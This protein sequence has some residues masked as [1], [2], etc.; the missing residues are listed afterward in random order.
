MSSP[1]AVLDRAVTVARTLAPG[2]LLRT[3]AAG[4]LVALPIV[5]LGYLSGVEGVSGVTPLAALAL[6]AGWLARG[7]I[8]A[9]VLRG[10]IARWEP[11]SLPTPRDGVG[12]EPRFAFPSAATHALGAALVAGILP[13]FAWGRLGWGALLPTL[14]LLALRVVPCP[15][16]LGRA[17]ESS[18]R[19]GGSGRPADP[20]R[21][22][23]AAELVGPGDRARAY[24]VEL[25]VLAATVLLAANLLAALGILSLLGRGVLGLDPATAEAF[26]SPRHGWAIA[27]VVLLAAG[28]LEPVRLGVAVVDAVDDVSRRLGLDIHRLIDEAQAA[29]RGGPPT[30]E[31]EAPAALVDRSSRKSV[32]RAAVLGGAGLLFPSGPPGARAQA[33]SGGDPPADGDRRDQE[34]EALAREILD[35]AAFREARPGGEESGLLR[36]AFDRLA[37]LLDALSGAEIPGAPG[38]ASAEGGLGWPPALVFLGLAGLLLAGVL[39]AIG[40]PRWLRRGDPESRRSRR[41]RASKAGRPAGGSPDAGLLD[42]VETRPALLFARGETLAREGRWR[43]AIRHFHRSG[44]ARLATA[45]GLTLRTHRPNGWYPSQLPAGTDRADLEALNACFD[46]VW[47]GPDG[48]P[49]KGAVD[50][51]RALARA[52]LRTEP[53]GASDRPSPGG[54]G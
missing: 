29:A 25:G 41:R 43:E 26:L 31:E 7:A 14:P 28:M 5:A 3:V 9:P 48:S 1:L 33:W 37:A 53:P 16:W 18:A 12:S 8:L 6:V 4:S 30:P 46:R 21:A 22:P 17:L 50:R 32:G 15:R 24:L 20:A 47:Y 27:L 54:E 35:G 38:L 34:V 10:Q 23:D 42:D 45:H 44:L 2:E 19:G 49:E 11:G 40:A 36:W 51:T 13:A 52:I 39:V